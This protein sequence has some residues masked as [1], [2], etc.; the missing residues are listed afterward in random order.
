MTYGFMDFYGALLIFW[1]LT[2]LLHMSIGGIISFF[3]RAVKRDQDI[4]IRFK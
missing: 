1:L 4:T 3:W 2:F